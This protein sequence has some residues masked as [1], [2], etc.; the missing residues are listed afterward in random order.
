M[1]ISETYLDKSAE[2]HPL[3]IDGYNL[4]RADHPHNKRRG[5]VCIYFKVQLKLKQIITPNFS[6]C[7]LF[8]M[9]LG[10]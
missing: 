7:V 6:E 2:S 10:K 4:I 3:L 9:R 8:E 5:G 1:C